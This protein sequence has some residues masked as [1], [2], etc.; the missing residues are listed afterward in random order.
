VAIFSEH[1]FLVFLRMVGVVLFFPGGFTVFPL[2]ARM[3]VAFVLSCAFIPPESVVLAADAPSAS[4]LSFGLEVM[5]GGILVFPFAIALK[6]FS[7]FAA[8]LEQGRG[9]NLGGMYGSS[10]DQEGS[11]QLGQLFEYGLLAVLCSVGLFSEITALL[12]ESLVLLPPGSL[13]V[14]DGWA[15]FGAEFLQYHFRV[16]LMSFTLFLPFGALFMVSDLGIG[17][18]SKLVSGLPIFAEM[19]VAKT[20][21]TLLL[22]LLFLVPSFE[23]LPNE[24][25]QFASDHIRVSFELLS[26]GGAR[27]GENG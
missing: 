13:F 24:I 16:L 8:L 27:G 3:A 10:P 6:G 25:A 4:P 2:T 19:F 21:I 18:I 11:G 7:M 26:E 22:L 15:L 9:Q 17:M 1:A 23:E 5:V 12:Q 14:H 20:T